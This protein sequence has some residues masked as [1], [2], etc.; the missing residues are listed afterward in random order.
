MKKN[1]NLRSL[2]RRILSGKQLWRSV[3]LYLLFLTTL[4]PLKAQDKRELVTLSVKQA[5]VVE[6]F[7]ILEKQVPYRFMYHDED[8]LKLGKKTFEFKQAP[9]TVVLDSCLGNSTVGY[10]FVGNQIVFKRVEKRPATV[11]GSISGVVTD[12]NGV[13]LPGVSVLLKGTKVGVSTNKDGQ[14]SLF[15]PD[16]T[17]VEVVV[18]FIGKK[19]R[20]VSYKNRSR[21]GS[22]VIVLEEDVKEV[23]EVVVT[24]YQKIDR[25]LSASSTYTVKAID[26][27][28]AGSTTIDDMLQGEIPGL[29]VVNTSGSPSALPKMRMRGTSTLLGN[30]APVWVIDGVIKEDPV[31]IANEDVAAALE[32]TNPNYL[33]FGNAISGLNPMDI[34]SITFLKD[35]SAT[36]IY[37]TRA[38]NGVIVVTTK[39]GVVGKTRLNYSGSFTLKQRPS[40]KKSAD[41]MNSQERMKLSKEFFEDGLIFSSTPVYGYE[42][43]MLDYLENKIPFSDVEREYNAREVLNTDWFD[44]LFSNAF[45]HSQSLSLSGGKDKT[46]YYAS[47][48]YTDDQGTANG[49]GVKRYTLGLRLETAITHWL[50]AD[51]KMDYSDRRV[52]AFNNVNP[53]DYALRAAR[54]LSPDERYIQ[55]STSISQDI[56]EGQYQGNYYFEY[57]LTYNVLDELR[58]TS[59]KGKTQDFSTT[60]FLRAKIIDG[61]KADVL[62]SYNNSRGCT[63]KWATDK[64]YAMAGLRGY[65]FGTVPAGGIEEKLSLY[66][67]GGKYEKEDQDGAMWMMNARLNFIKTW[68]ETNSINAMVGGEA[69]SYKRDGFETSEFGYFPDRGKSIYYEYNQPDAGNLYQYYGSSTAKHNVRLTDQINNKM[70]LLATLV[71]GYKGRYVL[72]ANFRVDASSRFGKKTNN[73]FLPIWSVAARWN[74]A[75]ETWMENQKLFDLLAF[76]VSYGSQGNVIST[77]GPD[78]VA[79][80]PVKP[81]DPQVG[82]YVLNLK[83]LPYP[84][85][86]WEKT[87]TINLGVEFS[88]FKGRFGATVEYYEKRG[89]ELLYTLEVPAELGVDAAYQ[90]GATIRNIG[91]D[92]NF[93]I[94]P[95]QMKNFKWTISPVLSLNRDKISRDTENWSYQQYLDGTVVL[96]GSPVS[97]FWSWKYKGLTHEEG[98]PV[99]EYDSGNGYTNTEMKDDPTKFL[100]Y[101]GRRNP[102]VTGGVSTYFTLYNFTLRG[103]FA[104]NLGAKVRLRPVYASGMTRT[105][106]KYYENIP[107][108]FVTHW[109]KPGDE[110]FTDNPGFV[111]PGGSYTYQHPAG[112]ENMYTMW[113][114]G[115]HRVVSGDFLRCRTIA[116]SYALPT[117]VTSKFGIEG[118][119]VAVS[120]NDLFVISNKKLRNQDPETSSSAIPRLPS[121]NFSVNISL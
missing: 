28:K 16:T 90:N 98:L 30:A 99:F 96:N 60:L 91:L 18:S 66:P 25:R 101:S 52:N 2:G 10:E 82:E 32:M 100:E 11:R 103:S 75:E 51:F 116:L 42:K 59:S 107:A 40:Y 48:S 89:K 76:K 29:M 114:A 53:M 105:A 85:L 97:A 49:D 46:S 31:N 54:T 93:S 80:Y 21:K 20:E 102:V 5:S 38:A 14:F 74:M 22:W 44:L 33:M 8:I 119:T 13:S 83:S 15:V 19:T 35:A 68:K 109:R 94:V 73:R 7:K 111:K 64:S 92:V 110:K 6:I 113:D 3:L 56:K 84:D 86:R 77:V 50:D 88:M 39:K 106:P 117:R 1:R 4:V 36:A 12:E 69:S 65:D 63:E 34:E 23:E 121:Y 70:S 41:V 81:I 78:M 27:M 24:G 72:N 47:A 67:Y 95:V 71:Y 55:S 104:Y 17:D 62:F 120:G 37:G 108:E 118:I 61:L 112:S 87:H 58:E 43:A 26:I 115:N 45:S 9:L 57:D 79:K